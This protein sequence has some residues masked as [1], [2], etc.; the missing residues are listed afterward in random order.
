VVIVRSLLKVT[1][2]RKAAFMICLALFVFAPF[3]VHAQDATMSAPAVLAQPDSVT[4]KEGDIFNVSVVIENLAANDGMLGVDFFLKWNSTILNAVNIYEVLFHEITP[5]SAWDNIWQIRLTI[6]NTKGTAEDACTWMNEP[7]AVDGGYCPVNGISG[8][9]TL[10]I[11]TMEAVGTGS[12]TLDLPYVLAAD[13]KANPLIDVGETWRDMNWSRN[14]SQPTSNSPGNVSAPGPIPTPENVSC[15]ANLTL[16]NVA[17][18]YANTVIQSGVPMPPAQ[19]A[20]SQGNV[21]G[22][23]KQDALEITEVPLVMLATMCG[24]FIALPARWRQVRREH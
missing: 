7:G 16:P 21:T 6:N 14:A 23:Q 18:F 17:A 12:T 3:L 20:P 5:Q 15:L 11:I 4:V 19:V 24:M 8:N 13:M 9:H 2:L 22:T 10:A 1:E